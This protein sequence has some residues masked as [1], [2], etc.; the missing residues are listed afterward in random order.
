MLQ[1]TKAI[2][3]PS[4]TLYRAGKPF[5]AATGGASASLSDTDASAGPGGTGTLLCCVCCS[6]VVRWRDRARL[7]SARASLAAVGFV[8]AVCIPS[9]RSPRV[10]TWHR[11]CRLGLRPWHCHGI[12]AS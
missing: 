4:T 9:R 1:M 5:A 10:S 6:R 7:L 2:M 11:L 8:N 12:A 3:Q